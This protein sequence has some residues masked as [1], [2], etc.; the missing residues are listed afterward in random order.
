MSLRV[1]LKIQDHTM[2]KEYKP[3]VEGGTKT[4][5]KPLPT[6]NLNPKDSFKAPKTVLEVKVFDFGKHK[7][8]ADFVNKCEAISSTY[9]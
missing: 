4:K 1:G 7:H 2:V 5:R 6:I 3:N 9:Q 8:A